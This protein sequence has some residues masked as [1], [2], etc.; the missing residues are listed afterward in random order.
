MV[1]TCYDR[2]APLFFLGVGGSSIWELKTDLSQKT[3]LVIKLPH[4]GGKIVQN[5]RPMFF[6]RR[7]WVE[8]PRP[9]E[10][11]FAKKRYTSAVARVLR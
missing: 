11:N 2:G 7:F 3:D 1:D 8:E 4:T 10:K 5:K 9:S 6:P